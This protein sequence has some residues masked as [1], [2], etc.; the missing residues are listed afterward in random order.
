M[1][2]FV[3]EI[4]AFP[5]NFAPRSWAYCQ[6]QTLP[7]SAYTT[8]FSVLGA[9][10]GGNGRST[11]RLPDLRGLAVVG[12]GSAPDL[13]SYL[14]GVVV[15]ETTVPLTLDQLPVHSHIP[16]LKVNATGIANMHTVPETGD[17]LSRFAAAGSPGAA[18]NTPPLENPDLFAA[19][20]VLPTGD[21]QPHPNQQPY[22][23]MNYYIAL[24]GIYPYRD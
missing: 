15:G 17:Q 24:S 23:S 13:S 14:P 20:M 4:R 18:F 16:V 10:Y 7:I 5:F 2:P 12:Q 8:L 6:G 22:L 11:F 3:G 1:V 9:T 21:G 19:E